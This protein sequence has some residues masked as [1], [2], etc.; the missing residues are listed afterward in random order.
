[1]SPS[2]PSPQASIPRCG[3]AAFEK[4]VDHVDHGDVANRTPDVS[5]GAGRAATAQL[6][7][8]RN[9]WFW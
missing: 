1:M 6:T 8:A 5:I 7:E 9:R 3:A 4:S 2:M